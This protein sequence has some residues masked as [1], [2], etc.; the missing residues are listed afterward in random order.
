MTRMVHSQ[1]AVEQ[2]QKITASLFSG[3]LKSL[4]ASDIEQGFK[5]VPSFHT[6]KED[7]GIV[8]LLVNAKISSSKRQARED[9]TN[10]AIYING[11]RQQ[12]LQ[13]VVSEADRIEGKFTI[14]RRGK[15]KYFLIQYNN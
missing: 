14:I 10:G 5:D 8:D 12:D 9:V 6:D 13:Y 1:E 11:E 2:A 7:I 15:K 4:S 3:D